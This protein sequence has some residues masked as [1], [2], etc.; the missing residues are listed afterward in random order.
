[1]TKQREKKFCNF[2][3]LWRS[4]FEMGFFDLIWTRLEM[5]DST[6]QMQVKKNKKTKK[7]SCKQYMQYKHK[8][9]KLPTY[10]PSFL[11][12]DLELKNW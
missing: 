5:K 10:C 11:A 3:L 8:S 9:H 2:E 1:M 4:I 12:K 6:H 7:T